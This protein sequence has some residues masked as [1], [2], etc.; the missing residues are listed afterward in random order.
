MVTKGLDNA[1][2]H[3]YHQLHE[4]GYAH[5]IEV[6][7]RSSSGHVRR[8]EGTLFCGESMLAGRRTPRNPAVG[9]V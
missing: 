1:W 7:G 3:A 5:S 6:W 8:G 2:H 4:L 9:L